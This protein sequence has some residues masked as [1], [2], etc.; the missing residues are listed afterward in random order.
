MRNESILGVKVFLETRARSP[1]PS[2]SQQT[3]RSVPDKPQVSPN[4]ST[5]ITD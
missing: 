1:E 3:A 4:V 5:K 2:S